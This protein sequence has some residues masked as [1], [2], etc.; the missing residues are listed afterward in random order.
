MDKKLSFFKLLLSLNYFIFTLSEYNTEYIIKQQC[1]NLMEKMK[2]NETFKFQESVKFNIEKLLCNMYSI[3]TD[4]NNKNTFYEKF[5]NVNNFEKCVTQIGDSFNEDSTFYSNFLLYSASRINNEGDETGCTNQNM[6]FIL[7]EMK[8]NYTNVKNYVNS[9]VN[10]TELYGLTQDKAEYY[11]LNGFLNNTNSYLSLCLWEECT[12]FYYAFFSKNINPEFYKFLNDEGF[13]LEDS[14][15]IVNSRVTRGEADTENV[16][17][18]KHL[19]LDKYKISYFICIVI[20]ILIICVRI[21]L[22]IIKLCS[23]RNVDKDQEYYFSFTKNIEKIMGSNDNNN[24]NNNN[25]HQ[26]DGDKDA[27]ENKK[28]LIVSLIASEQTQVEKYLDIYDYISSDNMSFL[29]SKSYNSK[30]FEVVCGFKFFMLLFMTIYRTYI[31]FYSVK[32]T[33]PGN[34]N[35]YHYWFHIL[36]LKLCV[37]CFRIWIFFDGFEWSFKFYSFFQE[38]KAKNI[39]IKHVIKFNIKLIEKILMFVLLL[40]LFIY[41]YA[42]TAHFFSYIP[43][44]FYLHYE[45]F[46]SPKCYNNPLYFLILPIIGYKEKIGGNYYCYDFAYIL[47]NEL[48]SIIFCSFLFY[49]CFKMKSK[50]LECVVLILFILS[51]GLSFFQYDV[52][53]KVYTLNYVLGEDQSLKCFGLFLNFFILGVL[54]GVGYFYYSDMKIDIDKYYPF[55][56][57]YQ[58][59]FPFFEMGHTLRHCIGL[60]CLLLIC[61][62]CCYYPFLLDVIY[63]KSEK[64]LYKIDFW[65][66]LIFIYEHIFQILLFKIFFFDIIL[67]TEFFIKKF[68]TNKIFIFCERISLVFLVI[69]EEIVFLFETTFNLSEIYWCLENAVFLSIVIFNL[70]LIFSTVIVYLFQLPIRLLVKKISMKYLNEKE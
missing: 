19:V 64:L 68:L 23:D 69:N 13:E 57:Y 44:N 66:S 67:S 8:I 61:L 50:F 46:K 32:W 55:H 52:N 2:N 1:Q 34:I 21:I 63:S 3:Y 10:G 9:I 43:S 6:T 5:K 36:T 20:L 56:N 35:F 59:M 48:Y 40:L 25:N 45:K 12:D 17:F 14:S 24:N 27:D 29:I 15:F 37:L 4:E 47:I 22:K 16:Y 58:I 38:L 28:N 51:I 65:K 18:G 30:N 42:S 60:F 39:S 62:T 11:E 70:L 26:V 7:F 49:L 31:T 53:N 54:S 33:T 41:Q